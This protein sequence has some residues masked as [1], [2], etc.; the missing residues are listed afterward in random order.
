MCAIHVRYSDKLLV[1]F[2]EFNKKCS[3]DDLPY[4]FSFKLRIFCFAAVQINYKRMAPNW[5][6]ASVRT[7]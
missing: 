1:P 4:M 5:V 7:R 2:Y 6:K 3:N